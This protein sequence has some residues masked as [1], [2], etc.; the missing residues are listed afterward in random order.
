MVETVTPAVCGTR[1]RQLVALALFAVGATTAA[2]TLGAVLGV[3]GAAIGTGPALAVAAALAVLGA[4]REAGVVR[5]AIPQ[6]KRQVPDWWRYE[7]PLP[8]W[9]AG[10]GA[11]LGLGVLT[12][13]P[14]ATF[15]VACAAAV[16]L[17]RPLAG[18]ATFAL[19]GLGRAAVLLLPARREADPMAIV[20]R[21]VRKRRTLLRA[22]A[23]ALGACAVLLAVSPV[24]GAAVMPLGPGNHMDPSASRSG[25]AYTKRVGSTV[26]VVIRRADGEPNVVVSDAESP[27][28]DRGY[29][30]YQGDDGLHVIRWRSGHEL[31]A[32]PGALE[33][34]ALAWPWLVYRKWHGHA[35]PRTATF[36]PPG[37][38]SVLQHDGHERYSMHLRNLV[39]GGHRVLARGTDGLELGRPS[40]EAG[41]VAWHASDVN[42]SKILVYTISN[43]TRSRLVSSKIAMHGN[44]ALT[45]W[46]I[47]WTR[48]L[49]GGTTLLTRRLN[50]RRSEEVASVARPATQYWFW[51][52][53][54]RTNRA[55]VT[56]WNFSRNTSRILLERL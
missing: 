1:K 2:A 32:L 49:A 45:R 11:G 33:K 50:G 44:P 40:I 25:F 56:R 21:L 3:A 27:A 37:R 19:Y 22:N 38:P 29:L 51:T 46:R 9:S 13:Q 54:L 36:R 35:A 17:G 47:L 28:L 23:V 42:G 18:A 8:V 39:T 41:R 34:P 15:W 53:E 52:T 26:S 20:E 30:A 55:Y 5:F 48:D 12:Y 14:V 24:A 10:Y 31:E 4:L 16:A 7:L 43:R 6:S